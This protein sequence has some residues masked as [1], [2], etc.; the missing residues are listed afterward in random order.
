MRPSET[1][2][3]TAAAL[4]A[5]RGHLRC[6]NKLIKEIRTRIND[7]KDWLS[8]LTTAM[9][10]D[11]WQEKDAA[12]LRKTAETVRKKAGSPRKKLRESLDMWFR[13]FQDV[14]DDCAEQLAA[15]DALLGEMI[16]NLQKLRAKLQ[17]KSNE[18]IETKARL[19]TE[20]DKIQDL[21]EQVSQNFEN[22]SRPSSQVPFRGKVTNSREATD[23]KPGGQ[24]GHEGHCRTQHEVNGDA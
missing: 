3:D 12:V 10:A 22:S 20:K 5:E 13:V 23:N 1:P 2:T 18:L 4:S 8:A 19:Q 11:S 6:G 7:L 17:K 14:Q 16:E 15:K 21:K 9:K 24:P